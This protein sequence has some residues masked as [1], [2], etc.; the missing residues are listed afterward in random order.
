MCIGLER[1]FNIILKHNT[2]EPQLFEKD[3]YLNYMDGDSFWK[4]L[5]EHDSLESK[6]D[7][8]EFVGEKLPRLYERFELLKQNFPFSQVYILF[9]F[10]DLISVA[11]S[12]QRRAQD[13]DDKFWG[14]A[15]NWE[16]ATKD[17]TSANK[18]YHKYKSELNILPIKYE[19]LLNCTNLEYFKN[20]LKNITDF[21]G[22][23]EFNK[24]ELT[25]ACN[26]FF[27]R[28]EIHGVDNLLPDSAIEL[29]A[30]ISQSNLS[31]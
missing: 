29:I 28:T 10:R 25:I 23:R 18:M 31:P 24:D 26:R 15:Q 20:E 11:E 12:Y 6:F 4:Q 7:S 1:Y 14:R 17:W 30:N 27:G 5:P 21:L 9:I 16:V 8:A 2:L 3:R 19:A 13:E 22:T